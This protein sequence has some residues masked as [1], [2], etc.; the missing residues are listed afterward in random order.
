MKKRTEKPLAEK[1][2][3]FLEA[4]PALKERIKQ[5]CERL[6]MTQAALIRMAIV[7]FLEEEEGS[8]K[9]GRR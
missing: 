8:Y 6:G 5:Q 9:K 7:K 1:Q 3:L 2:H 4:T